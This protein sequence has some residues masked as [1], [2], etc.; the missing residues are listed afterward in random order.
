MTRLENKDYKVVCFGEVL[1]DVLG[2]VY[3]PGGAPFNVS[4]HLQQAEVDSL[5]ISSIGRDDLGAE[6]LSILDNWNLSTQG[7]KV[8]DKY[9]TGEAVVKFDADNQPHYDLVFPVAWDFIP[10]DD[11]YQQIINNSKAF[12]FG[13]LSCRN[14][15]S[16]TTLKQCLANSNMNVFDVN[17][18]P[19]YVNQSIIEDLLQYAHVLKLNDSELELLT[20]WYNLHACNEKEQVGII[21]EKFKIDEVI[22]TKGE[23]GVSYYND[24]VELHKPA[25]KISVADTVG[26]GDAFLA[27]F[28]AKKLD[29]YNSIEQCLDEGIYRSAFVA[30]QS[31]ACPNYDGY[32]SFI[33]D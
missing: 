19:P 7:V 3:K 10:W 14:E 24:N 28:L 6:L 25:K 21:K 8:S 12:V 9:K 5:L 27:G 32:Q 18:R 17:I 33:K 26:S 20:E 13:S 31:G 16:L 30:T 29:K 11:S 2:D 1:F 4:Y 15:Q 23:G 22:I